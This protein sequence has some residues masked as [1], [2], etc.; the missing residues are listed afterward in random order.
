MKQSF[1]RI[2]PHLYK[3]Q[4]QAVNGESSTRYYAIFV[5]WKGK[6]RTFPLGSVLKTAKEELKRLL[7]LSNCPTQGGQ[8]NLF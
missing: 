7:H 2:A 4:N 3:R 5:D 8:S 6:R 1:K